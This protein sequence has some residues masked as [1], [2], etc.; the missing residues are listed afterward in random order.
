MIAQAFMRGEGLGFG[1]DTSIGLLPIPAVLGYYAIFFGFG[2]IYFD[3]TGTE[4]EMDQNRMWSWIAVGIS[5]FVLFPVGIAINSQHDG[6]GQMASL[7]TQSSYAWLMTFGLMGVFRH[8]LSRESA[9][10]RY[11]SDSS[12]WLY[13]AHIP[14]II[15]LQYW[16][17][18]YQVSAF[19]K[20][21]I[22]CVVSSVILLI[23]YHLFVRYTPIGTLLNGKRY[24]QP[25]I[26]R[27][28][29][30]P[31]G[32]LTGP[33]AAGNEIPIDPEGSPA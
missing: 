3:S 7:F 6:W 28:N 9:A 4:S 32:T 10:L 13:L 20:F 2:A 5:L 26:D 19:I 25:T 15:Y 27:V 17:R 22:V 30:A 33:G 8:V 23:S 12:Y 31:S 24:R 11:L 14:L 21:P 16:V 1:P 18:D 29:A